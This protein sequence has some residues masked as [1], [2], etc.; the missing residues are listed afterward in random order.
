M[1]QLQKQQNFSGFDLSKL[2]ASLYDMKVARGT[3]EYLARFVGW[4]TRNEQDVALFAIKTQQGEQ[5]RKLVFGRGD[6][7]EDPRRLK[8]L[9]TLVFSARSFENEEFVPTPEELGMVD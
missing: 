2:Q 8:L 1:A 6:K 9:F 4:E 5:T 3:D 7:V